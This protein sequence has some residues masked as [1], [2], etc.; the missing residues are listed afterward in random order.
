[1]HKEDNKTTGCA[2]HSD[3]LC[4]NNNSLYIENT[5]QTSLLQMI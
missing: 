1:M 4:I 5:A 3:K 2:A